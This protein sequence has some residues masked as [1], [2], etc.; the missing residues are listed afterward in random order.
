[1][2]KNFSFKNTVL[3]IFGAFLASFVIQS[4]LYPD[5][6]FFHTRRLVISHE[7]EVPMESTFILI[8]HFFHG[9]IQLWDRFDQVNNAFFVA[10]NGVYGVANVI[11]AFIYIILSPFFTHP[12]EAFYHTH[13]F[14]FY[15]LTCLIRTIGG[16][17]LLRKLTSNKAVLFISLLYLNTILTSYMMTPGLMAHGVYS[18]L[19][20]LMY[21][22]LCFFEDLRLR[23]FLSVMLVM[24]LC[25]INSPYFTFGYFYQAVH[26][27]ILSCIVNFLLQ[28]G[29]RKLLG[30]PPLPRIEFLKNMGLVACCVLILLPYYWWGHA[31]THDFYVHGSGLGG[32]QGRFNNIFNFKGYFNLFSKGFANSF[33]FL[34]TTLDYQHNCHTLS[35]IFMGAST[36]FFTLAG[37][38]LSK[39]RRKYVFAGSILGVIMINNAWFPGSFSLLEQYI[40]FAQQAPEAFWARGMHAHDWCSYGFLMLSTVAHGINALTNPFCFL[41]RS[42]HMVSLL[43]PMLFLPLIAMGLE[44][45][46][47]LWQR[48]REAIHFNRRWFLVIFF[49]FVLGWDLLG[50]TQ[51]LSVGDIVQ[52]AA[53]QTLK[54]YILS[55]GTIFLLFILLPEY[56][57]A[58]KK[59]VVLNPDTRRY[60]GWIIL[61]F[62][63]V[64]DFVALMTYNQGYE[65]KYLADRNPLRVSPCYTHQA[66]VPDYQNPRH[67]LPLREFLNVQGTNINPPI[68]GGPLDMYG[69]F[70]QYTPIGRFFHRWSI[71]EPRHISYKDLYPDFEIQ[72]YLGDNQRTIFFADFAFDSKYIKLADILRLNLGQRVVIA[73]A[74]EYNSSFLKT[75]DRVYMP[76]LDLSERIYNVPLEW[77]KAKIHKKSE[78]WEYSFDVPKDFPSYLSTT[79]FTNDYGSW[80]LMINGRLLGPMQGELTTPFTYDVQNIQDRKIT[81][82][83]PD[84]KVPQ[85]AANLQVKLPKGILDVWKNT[86]DDLG[87][88]YDAPRAGWLVFNYPY[89]EKW[90]LSIDNQNIPLSKVDRYFMGAPISGGEHRV[91]LQYWPHT[92][93]RFLI[94]ISMLFS[95]LCLG[96]MIYYSIKQEP[97]SLRKATYVD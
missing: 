85:E 26:F 53:T 33:E 10:T 1:M 69:A 92:Y 61:G 48:K 80:R 76:P 23:T 74:N 66:V 75:T 93:L 38:I 79:V 42:F 11:T 32:T 96:G 59:W 17:L 72:Q 84:T 94:F 51:A 91:L 97:L 52:G 25:L 3:F 78:G 15:G 21:F 19:P 62:A 28:R 47:Y 41:V 7:T 39:D 56:L 35:W 70:Y 64:V 2:I 58:D 82:L 34:G 81:I 12:G 71:Y 95:V 18:F 4:L 77:N 68:Y 67:A 5:L 36:L 63:F 40:K 73:E 45:C 22:I 60:L 20:L 86:Y 83:L 43:V 87:L 8:S 44:S 24:T 49:A 89:D 55:A 65:T 46:L 90:E 29:W 13:M 30:R 27:F 6:W 16:Y 57:D 9:G 54:G 31:L 50:G 37:M 88:T 14:L